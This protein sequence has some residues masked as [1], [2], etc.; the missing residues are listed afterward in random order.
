M[1]FGDRPALTTLIA[2]ALWLGACAPAAAPPASPTIAPTSTEPPA[3]PQTARP[4][5]ATTRVDR[6]ITF[7][8]DP[9]ST[10]ARFIIDEILR[11]APN[12]V[13]GSTA[14]V[15]GEIQIDLGSPAQ[16]AIGPIRIEAGSLATDSGF[17]DRAI[18]TFILQTANFPE[19]TFTPL[20][21]R[22]CPQPLRSATH[23][24][25]PSRASWPSATSHIP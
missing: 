15:T 22:V 4:A 23:S 3:F 25:S 19:V 18:R 1:L 13:V 2:L 12:T 20:P 24:P 7:V 14:Q 21:W 6:V 17:R 8:L 11:G 5:T 10:Q 16:S 9:G